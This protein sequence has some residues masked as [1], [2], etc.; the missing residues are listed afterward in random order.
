MSFLCITHLGGS[1]WQLQ[2]IGPTTKHS[3][4]KSQLESREF[5]IQVEK[6]DNKLCA[7]LCCKISLC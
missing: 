6:A 7:K 1:V 5:L 2:G 3:Y 4:L